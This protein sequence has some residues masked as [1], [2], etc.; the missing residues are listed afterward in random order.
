MTMGAK[1][2]YDRTVGCEAVNCK[3]EC[4]FSA[5]SS[6]NRRKRIEQSLEAVTS[7]GEWNRAMVTVLPVL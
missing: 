2:M 3:G 7:S 1:H 5:L 6:S 4:S